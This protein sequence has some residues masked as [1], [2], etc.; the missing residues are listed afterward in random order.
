MYWPGY[1]TSKYSA[2]LFALERT[3]G[4]CGNPIGS[5]M[6]GREK[7]DRPS[8]FVDVGGAPMPRRVA[9]TSGNSTQAV[10]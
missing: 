5:T 7:T 1:V 10:R 2:M 4:A 8:F 3:I 9:S 6:T